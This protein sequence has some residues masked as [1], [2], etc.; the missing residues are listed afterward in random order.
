V[1]ERA[2]L[3]AWAVLYAA[4]AIAAQLLAK[5]HGLPLWLADAISIVATVG[6]LFMCWVSL[7]VRGGAR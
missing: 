6:H 5:F 2:S 7:P 4:V 1:N 3:L